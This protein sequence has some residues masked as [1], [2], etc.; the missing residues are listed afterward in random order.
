MADPIAEAAQKH[1]APEGLVYQYGTAG[2]STYYVTIIYLSANTGSQ[3]R[4]RA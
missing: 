1:P 3:F 4:T 2:V